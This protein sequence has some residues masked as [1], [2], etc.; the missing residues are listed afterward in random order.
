MGPPKQDHTV[1]DRVPFYGNHLPVNLAALK[2]IHGKLDRPAFQKILRLTVSGFEGKPVTQDMLDNLS[3]SSSVD[4]EVIYTT[5]AGLLKLLQMAI[6]HSTSSWTK[7]MFMAD[8]AVLGLPQEYADDL[9]SAVFG[10]RRSVLDVAADNK[11][12]RF[13]TIVDMKWKIEV[14]IS[15]TSLNRVLEPVVSM[16]LTLS[17][18]KVKSF[19]M[20]TTKFQELRYNAASVLKEMENLEKRSVF[21]IQD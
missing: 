13:P 8:I 2:K 7:E 10:S 18:G 21:K 15:T 12:P 17:D 11:K 16:Q 20:S 4:A 19:E 3:A 14:G 6:K 1:L 9:T 5:Y